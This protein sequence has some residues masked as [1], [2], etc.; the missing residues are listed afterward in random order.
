MAH[1]KKQDKCTHTHTHHISFLLSTCTSACHQTRPQ[2]RDSLEYHNPQRAWTHLYRRR[3]E[4]VHVTDD[5]PAGHQHEEV[6]EHVLFLGIPEGVCEFSPILQ[7]QRKG[8]REKHG[9]TLEDRCLTAVGEYLQTTIYL[10]HPSL[11]NGNI[12]AVKCTQ[13]HI[14]AMRVTTIVCQEKFIQSVIHNTCACYLK[15]LSISLANSL[16]T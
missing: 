13:K 15:G 14:C 16:I 11:L 8:G 5:G 1:L 12:Q 7:Q 9:H 4:V 2:T 10:L 3:L 6:R